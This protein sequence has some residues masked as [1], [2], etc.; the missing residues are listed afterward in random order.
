MIGY[1]VR[2]I[3]NLFDFGERKDKI[4]S[5]FIWVGLKLV[6]ESLWFV[7]SIYFFLIF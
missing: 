3:F 2:R 1:E 7:L 5:F 6:F 4:M